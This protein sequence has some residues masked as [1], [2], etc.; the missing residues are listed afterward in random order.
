MVR[1]ISRKAIDKCWLTAPVLIVLAFGACASSQEDAEAY[2]VESERAWAESVASGDTTTIER[3][4]ADDFVGVDPEGRTYDKAK[5]I[6]DT[7][8]APN[9]FLSNRLN[10]AKVRFFGNTAVVQGDESWVRRTGEQLCGRFVWTDTW[11]F[12]NEHRQ[13]VA[14]E[15]LTRARGMRALIE[16]SGVDA[17]DSGS[18]SVCRGSRA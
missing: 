12:R 5:M 8:E 7:R 17:D 15:D 6:A 11:L 9:Y 1:G 13:I 16:D 4:L 14:A 10:R 3:I 18:F 2:I